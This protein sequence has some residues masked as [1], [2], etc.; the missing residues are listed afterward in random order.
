M[1][2][3]PPQAGGS[4][5]DLKMVLERL[6]QEGVNELWVEAGPTL[7]GALLRSGLV[8]ELI[9]YVAPLLMGDGAR[10][11]FQLPEFTRIADCPALDI[12]DVRAV[13]K[14]WRVSARIRKAQDTG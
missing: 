13:G 12:S 10:G 7:S 8:D 11:L 5:V 4:G 3:V 9:I 6:A 14:D 2:Y 1:E